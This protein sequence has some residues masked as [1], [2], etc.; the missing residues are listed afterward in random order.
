MEDKVLN[1]ME[2]EMPKYDPTIETFTAPESDKW[3]VSEIIRLLRFYAGHRCLWDVE[4]EDNN[5]RR[6]RHAALVDITAAMGG[7]LT[8]DQ[9]VQKINIIRATYRYEKKRIKQ[10]MKLG[11]G[12]KTKL[13]WFALADAFL[14][15]VPKKGQKG[16][17][18]RNSDSDLEDAVVFTINPETLGPLLPHKALGKGEN[19]LVAGELPCQLKMENFSDDNEFNEGHEESDLRSEE[20]IKP[21][22]EQ[23]EENLQQQ[24][25]ILK[26][27]KLN[28]SEIKKEF[29]KAKQWTLE[30]SLEFINL[31]KQYPIVCSTHTSESWKSST[32]F[33]LQTIA[34]EMQW[35]LESIEK[36]W[37]ILKETVTKERE[38]ISQDPTYQPP[39][40][41]W[42]ETEMLWEK[43][44]EIKPETIYL[45]EM[46]SPPRNHTDHEEDDYEDYEKRF[47]NPL[48]SVAPMSNMNESLMSSL[49]REDFSMESAT[50]SSYPIE[51]ETEK[52]MPCNKNV[53]EDDLLEGKWSL[54]HSV[55]F[56][57]LYG[58]HRCLWDLKDPDYRS[59]ALRNAAIE[60][61]AASMGHGLT[62]AYV[63]KKIKIFRI[64]YMQQR[65]RILETTRRGERPEILLKWFPLADSF[66]RP[67]IGLRSIKA[68][69]EEVVP[70]FDF[71]YVYANLNLIDPGLL[72]DFRGKGTQNAIDIGNNENEQS[73]NGE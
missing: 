41:W 53:M 24:L 32:N 36:R 62:A 20:A 50:N 23:V 2:H 60:D 66:L 73:S 6:M 70:Q 21:K 30:T 72:N 38:K 40:K 28:D 45:D 42:Q 26:E 15:N 31:L 11:M 17:E 54:K 63:A 46:K 33:P 43:P 44:R 49:F 64:T 34:Q 52:K 5:N 65:K 58:V 16:E 18:A 8:K 9:V 29:P 27:E 68:D 14:R 22:L 51:M 4:H 25:Q 10:R 71:Q 19:N 7:H 55:K 3:P 67:H 13:K 12:S 59:R 57:R 47:E 48:P 69:V 37:H 61:I 35:P 1:N 39:Y 56:L